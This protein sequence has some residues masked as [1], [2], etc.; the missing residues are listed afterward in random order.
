LK[1]LV[2]GLVNQLTNSHFELSDP[3]RY[4]VPRGN[5][6]WFM[7]CPEILEMRK[8][9]YINVVWADKQDNVYLESMPVGNVLEWVEQSEGED[10]VRQVLQMDLT[11][12]GTRELRSLLGRDFP[13]IESRLA[14][15]EEIAEE[16]SS[17]RRV[18]V[19][20]IWHGRKGA[21]AC[22]LRSVIRFNDSSRE[23]MKTELESAL[24]ALREAF[25]KI[26]KYEVQLAKGLK[27]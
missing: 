4:P 19:E 13:T 21:T 14:A 12:L 20:L 6:N 11:G 27:G 9:P 1:E 7:W 2:R 10:A 23:S 3:N 16:V 8:I 22:R 24:G 25:D 17:R 26:D 15:C 5:L 18:K